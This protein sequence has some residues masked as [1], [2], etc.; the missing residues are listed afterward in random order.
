MSHPRTKSQ[1]NSFRIH[2]MMQDYVTVIQSLTSML[3]MW[4]L[5]SVTHSFTQSLT[6]SLTHPHIHSNFTFSSTDLRYGY[7]NHHASYLFRKT[8]VLAEVSVINKSMQRPVTPAWKSATSHIGHQKQCTEMDVQNGCG[9]RGVRTYLRRWISD[10][11]HVSF[12]TVTSIVVLCH[13]CAL[14]RNQKKTYF[15]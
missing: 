14:T 8:T 6:H 13:E 7:I 2:S 15:T 3:E 4:F 12:I 1:L 9:K 11:M 5:H 10:K